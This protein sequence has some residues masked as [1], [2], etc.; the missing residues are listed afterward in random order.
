MDENEQDIVATERQITHLSKE[1][2]EI[3]L[4]EKM[5]DLQKLNS[6]FTKVNDELQDLKKVKSD[7]ISAVVHQFRMPLSGI[8]WTLSMLLS[9]DMGPLN[10]DQKNFLMKS[11]ENNARLIALVND[12]L[13]AGKIQSGKDHYELERTDIVD[14][15]DSVFFEIELQASKRDV[16]IKYDKE[17]FKTL[18][19]VYINQ[20]TMRV[21]LQSL[22][23]NAVKYTIE[24]GKVELDA[25]RES[26]HLVISIG[27]NGI[28]IPKDQMKDVF[29]KF[30]RA[31][32]AIKQETDGSGLGL[33][34]TKTIVEKNGGKI[35]FE[36]AEGKGSTFYF[37][38]P[39]QENH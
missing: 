2:L 15:I 16:T 30:F 39:L 18:S 33:Y 28:G 4:L 27:D 9:G 23:E 5:E 29:T 25:K 22:L 37:T 26:D 14:L 19:A 3:L 34:I 11:Y 21:V 1:E 8:K 13:I 17:K 10:N 36:S 35:W 31:R 20:E 12:I 7:S 32:N 38:I 24:G 6:E